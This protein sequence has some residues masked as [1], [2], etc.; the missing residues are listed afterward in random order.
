MHFLDLYAA[1]FL[2]NSGSFSIDKPIL[3]PEVSRDM[4]VTPNFFF[5]GLSKEKCQLNTSNNFYSKFNT[6]VGLE[7]SQ[8]QAAQQTGKI[9]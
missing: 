6:T 7:S 3:K 5:Q 4:A 8:L 9:M 1:R 2:H